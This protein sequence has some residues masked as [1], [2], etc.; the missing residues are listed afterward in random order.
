MVMR[1]GRDEHYNRASFLAAIQEEVRLDEQLEALCALPRS[2]KRV[3]KLIQFQDEHGGWYRLRRMTESL[4]PL[5]A[6]EQVEL[7]NEIEQAKN[8][9]NQCAL[10]NLA[11]NLNL[12]KDTFEVIEPFMGK[13]HP[14]EVR[15]AAIWAL[16]RID[17]NKTT[18][19]LLPQ[20]TLQ[21]PELHDAL[22][23]LQ[24]DDPA[25][26]LKIV[27]VLLSLSKEM[28]QREKAHARQEAMRQHQIE[29]L[30][31][32]QTLKDDLLMRGAYPEPPNPPAISWQLQEAMRVQ[33]VKHVHPL[34]LS[35]YFNWLS[36]NQPVSPAYVTAYLQSMLGVRWDAAKLLA[37]WEQNHKQVMAD[38]PLQKTAGCEQWFTV[39]QGG[40]E[41]LQHFLVRLWVMTP[42]TNQLALVKAAKEEKTAVMA[43]SVITELWTA[44]HLGNEAIQ[45]MFENFMR[46]EFVD[47]ATNFTSRFKY[48]HELQIILKFDYPFNTCFYFRTPMIVDGKL[49]ETS[50]SEGQLC[51][52]PSLKEYRLGCL[53]GYVP[54]KVATGT[55]EV[56]HRE[57]YPDGKILWHAHWNLGPIPLGE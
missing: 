31:K 44:N 32:S 41:T 33:L 45:A 42:A 40:D 13:D 9:T 50:T 10:L 26:D 5:A 56:F 15:Q 24:A 20:M 8:S 47:A 23:V 6:D 57:H 21:L 2:A 30:Q 35:F 38:Y 14:P 1:A 25:M 54:G 51:P 37:W 39:Y 53:G 11:A 7:L 3:R 27:D 28:R 12:S 22:N 36:Q 18:Q 49:S 43:K 16:S 4:R 52:E 34:L 46:V 48:Q 17:A 19:L 29:Q 55:L